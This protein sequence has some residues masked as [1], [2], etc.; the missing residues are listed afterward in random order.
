MLMVMKCEI[1][2]V[3]FVDVLRLHYC[4]NY[5]A[6]FSNGNKY[7]QFPAVINLQDD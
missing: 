3:V 1:D 4:M 6:I 2:F 7:L 5:S